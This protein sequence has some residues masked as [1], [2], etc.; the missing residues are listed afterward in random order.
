MRSRLRVIRRLISLCSR[1]TAHRFRGSGSGTAEPDILQLQDLRHT[2]ER[3]DR[4][5]L[6]RISSRP[7]QYSGARDLA[8]NTMIPP[9]SFLPGCMVLAKSDIDDILRAET[10]GNGEQSG[11]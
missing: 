10:R 6:S 7:M 2:I 3:S 11:K 9:E 8:G 1:I 5:A 4:S